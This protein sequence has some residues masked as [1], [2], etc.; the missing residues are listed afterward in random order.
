MKRPTNCIHVLILHAWGCHRK[1]VKTEGS[2][3]GGG[4]L[5]IILTEKIN[6][7][8]TRNRKEGWGSQESELWE[9]GSEVYCEDLS[10]CCFL[11]L[12]GNE[13]VNTFTTGNR[14]PVFRHKGEGQQTFFG[15]P[16]CLKIV[17]MSK[18]HIWGGIFQAPSLES[19]SCQR[20]SR[21]KLFSII[22]L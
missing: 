15:F 9:G 18:R 21:G 4:G 22:L 6:C 17:L 19:N 16:D 8:V 3:L 12:S 5:I 1:E 2:R 11:G 20:V 7:R 13:A 14:C 10:Q